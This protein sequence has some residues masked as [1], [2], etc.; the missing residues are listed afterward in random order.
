MSAHVHSVGSAVRPRPL[1]G[2]TA[3]VAGAAAA[4]LAAGLAVLLGPLALAAL[5][6]ALVGA[7]LCREPLLLYV[8]FLYVGVFKDEPFV[9]ALPVDATAA[10]GGLL[11]LVLL[12]RLYQQRVR[13]PPAPYVGLMALLA[14]WMVLALQWSPDPEYGLDKLLKFVTL[15][16][17]A[18]F[19]PFFLIE[20]RN[21]LK[22]L[23]AFIGLA[24]LAG[25]LFAVTFGTT[26]ETEQTG[27]RLVVGEATN[28]IYTSRFLITGALV[29]A[30]APALKIW[31]RGRIVAPLAAVGLVALA[32]GIGSRGPLVAL[33]LAAAVTGAAVILREPRRLLPV[34]LVAVAGIAA[35]PFI[36]LP[37][38]SKERLA[39]LTE[40]PVEVLEED[41]RAPLY[42]TAV[43]L[44][45]EHPVL[46]IGTG[47]FA[48]YSGVLPGDGE[49][50]PHNVFLEAGAELGIVPVVALAACILA[51]VLSLYRRAWDTPD[52]R[53]RNMV[54]LVGGIFLLNL[55]AT[56]FSGDFNDNRSFWAAMGLA[57]LVARY[58]PA[59]SPTT[60][61]SR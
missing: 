19:A 52:E 29:L 10:L 13:R 31:N 45:G 55:F 22:K 20:G 8:A 60:A 38:T 44:I 46:G 1:T 51:L 30:L 25:G 12:Q 57:W 61:E 9:E 33:V 36:S 58:G 11:A 21:D 40:H 27:D 53:E 34:V 14:L 32:L 5:A 18:A 54:Y 37:E 35:F 43:D 49:K 23:L 7:A 6:A 15:T 17:I 41:V 50:Y 26:A 24:A 56:Q 48:I 3:L 42:A 39:G 2:G 47:G 16:L 4:L 28:T 59:P